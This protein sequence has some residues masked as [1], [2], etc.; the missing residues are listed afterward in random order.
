[1]EKIKEYKGIYIQ[2]NNEPIPYYEH[3]A[4]FSYKELYKKLEE[5]IKKNIYNNNIKNI[6]KLPCK[7]VLANLK[8][9]NSQKILRYKNNK[10][11][12]INISR[13]TNVNRNSIR[14]NNINNNGKLSKSKSINKVLNFSKSYNDE[15]FGSFLL[16]KKKNINIQ[17]VKDIFLK[18]SLKNNKNQTII[19]NNIKKN[20]K[21]NH[22]VLKYV[23]MPKKK[24][25]KKE[26]VIN[27]NYYGISP[28]KNVII[29]NDI[30]SYGDISYNSTCNNYNNKIKYDKNFL[31]KNN[32][33]ESNSKNK[34]STQNVKKYKKIKITSIINKRFIQKL[35]ND[36]PKNNSGFLSNNNS[37]YYSQSKTQ[38]TSE[39][40]IININNYSY[41]KQKS[42]CI[43][44][45]N[46]NKLYNMKVCNK[47][48]SKNKINDNI[49]YIENNNGF[50]N[51]NINKNILLSNNIKQKN[52]KLTI[53]NLFNKINFQ[54]K[55]KINYLNNCKNAL[56]FEE[57]RKN[58]S[59]KSSINKC[60]QKVKQ[61]DI[62]NLKTKENK[63]ISYINKNKNYNSTSNSK[64]K[65]INKK[66]LKNHYSQ[67]NILNL[68]I[69]N[70]ANTP[71][72]KGKTKHL[73]T[74]TFCVEEHNLTTKNKKS[75]NVSKNIVNL[76]CCHFSIN[77]N[78]PI[79]L[80]SNY[81]NNITNNNT[82]NKTPKISNTT[83]AVNNINNVSEIKNTEKMDMDKNRKEVNN[84]IENNNIDNH[85]KSNIVKTKVKHSKEIEDKKIK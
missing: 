59:N 31:N 4:H 42:S 53:Y 74:L 6:N 21:N 35:I 10:I 48:L 1:M 24:D 13:N 57:K 79:N 54:K 56:L 66:K 14:N 39:N 68:N 83:M 2:D 61:K 17:K 11:V 84:N 9:A 65:N 64:N 19:N 85:R 38:R 72:L 73:D 20:I 23:I 7:R 27:S 46:N 22:T 45:F 50:Y 33:N 71:H 75:R 40:N 5:I 34:E 44:K 51:N 55:N 80:L 70:E 43:I 63:N 8:K 77:F 62:C 58:S 30:N 47:N 78:S 3:G 52:K 26:N 12:R 15:Q 25:N 28:N 37:A 49:Y 41:K 76:L 81:Q 29:D 16:N 69:Q 60:H 36:S 82:N 67:N 18:K 32:Q